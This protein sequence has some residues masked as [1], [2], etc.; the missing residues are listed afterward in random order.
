ME[1][2]TLQ[3]NL[4]E[5]EPSGDKQEVSE[6]AKNGDSSSFSFPTGRRTSPRLLR[7]T[8]SNDPPTGSEGLATMKTT[9]RNKASGSV[10]EPSD[11]E[12][13]TCCVLKDATNLRA[14][15][16]HDP[17][18]M[19]QVGTNIPPPC[20]PASTK[21][22][23][24]IAKS[25]V[26]RESLLASN[27]RH[28]AVSLRR[29]RNQQQTHLSLSR[30]PFS[31]SD[32]PF[33][34]QATPMRVLRKRKVAPTQGS[35]SYNNRVGP[36]VSTTMMSQVPRNLRDAFPV[37]LHRMITEADPSIAWWDKSGKAF[38]LNMFSK[39]LPSTLYL[40]FGTQ[41][42]VESFRRQ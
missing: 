37:A 1:T 4:T 30:R 3:T 2:I 23:P 9:L 5:L 34:E 26:A 21:A 14:D 18:S 42:K 39:N 17:K 22:P 12:G 40:F 11:K 24:I 10:T 27:R 38:G 41:C 7:N 19:T 13:D 6:S 8:S 16:N 35:F 32:I 29:E 25:T 28:N 36:R 33:P 20:G 31:H 15:L